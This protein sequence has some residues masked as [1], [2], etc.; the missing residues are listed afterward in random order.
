M[1]D[2]NKVTVDF[3][4]RIDLSKLDKFSDEQLQ[5]IFLGLALVIAANQE[6]KSPGPVKES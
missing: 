1:S 5:A 3:S 6:Q 2:F 4:A